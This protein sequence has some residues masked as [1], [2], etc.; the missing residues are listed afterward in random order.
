MVE[1]K[2]MFIFWASTFTH[3]IWGHSVA[4]TFCSKEKAEDALITHCQTLKQEEL[5]RQR[6][7]EKAKT[8]TYR[9]C[10]DILRSN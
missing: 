5:N 2:Y 9:T 7:K 6:L 1:E 10:E 4:E 8:I 3:T